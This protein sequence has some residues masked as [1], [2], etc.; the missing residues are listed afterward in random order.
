MNGHHIGLFD[1]G[2]ISDF[3]YKISN[4]WK[5]LFVF[6]CTFSILDASD[7]SVSDFDETHK[8]KPMQQAQLDGPM[9][10]KEKPQPKKEKVN[11]IL[12]PNWKSI[13]QNQCNTV[14]GHEL[15]YGCHR[16]V[17]SLTCNDKEWTDLNAHLRQMSNFAK[18]KCRTLQ[19][20]HNLHQ[21]VC[22]AEEIL[23]ILKDLKCDTVNG[24]LCK[25]IEE[26]MEVCVFNLTK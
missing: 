9:K 17:E 14:Q 19:D 1:D 10:V 20:V 5:M 4:I 15:I 18:E 26:V 2:R 21:V 3:R 7:A 8:E 11:T 12:A 25:S 23:T 22:R 6:A 24:L 16:I 13:V